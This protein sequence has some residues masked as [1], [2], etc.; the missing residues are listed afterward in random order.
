MTAAAYRVLQVWALAL[1][2][3]LY[4]FRGLLEY[5][6]TGWGP[7]TLLTVGIGLGVLPALAAV[8]ASSPPWRRPL[9]AGFCLLGAVI[10]A[11]LLLALWAGFT[12]VAGLTLLIVG[13]YAAVTGI[14]VRPA[15]RRRRP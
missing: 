14:E 11:G 9:L 8:A 3:A 13:L 15:W 5:P 4:L 10:N 7:T 2:A 1:L 6:S 12:P